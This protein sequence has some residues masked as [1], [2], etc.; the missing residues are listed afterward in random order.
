MLKQPIE[1]SRITPG[2]KLILEQIGVDFYPVSE[3]SEENTILIVN[4]DSV[5][6]PALL[7]Q[8]RLLLIE[9]KVAEKYYPSSMKFY[10]YFIPKTNAFN[11]IG[12]PDYYQKLHRFSKLEEVDLGVYKISDFAYVL[13][14]SM[15]EIM[16]SYRAK[17]KKF[18]FPRKELPS[19]IVAKIDKSGIRRLIEKLLNELLQREQIPF[20]QKKFFPAENL[21]LFRIDTDFASLEDAKKML[22]L[23]EKYEIKATWF[24]E[25]TD[26]KKITDFYAKM[27]HQEIGL[28]CYRH[29][30]FKN[31]R[32]N[33]LNL[34]YGKKILTQHGIEPLGFAAPYGEWNPNLAKAIQDCGFLYSSE[35]ALDYDD[36]PFYPIVNGRQ[37]SVLQIP[38]H[39][40]SLGRLRRSHFSQKDMKQYF[41]RVIGEKM[42]LQEPIAIYHHPSH[43]LWEVIEHIFQKVSSFSN[44]SFGEYAIWWKKR[45]NSRLKATFENESISVNVPAK[46]RKKEQYTFI[47]GKAEH[48]IWENSEKLNLTT[49]ATRSKVFSWRDWLYNYES[50]QGKRKQ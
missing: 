22:A 33:C 29:R 34:K 12:I 32:R 15:D 41:D 6:L 18:Y 5:D 35:F 13:P 40:I 3:T 27:E 43:Q 28:H 7:Q 44:M 1:I 24:I 39:P 19:E 42:I 49:D 25:T 16:N 20:V 30:V 21:F 48:L 4:D 37:S 2:W 17:R 10:T 45:L 14:F 11:G 38:I 47:K 36:V 26:A 31:Y 8:K 9:P 23:L 50:Y 46:A